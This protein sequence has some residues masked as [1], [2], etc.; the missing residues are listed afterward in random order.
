[1]DSQ[2]QNTGVGLAL[3]EGGR[4]LLDGGVK[5]PWLLG[6]PP[7]GLTLTPKF[8]FKLDDSSREFY[9]AY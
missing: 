2:S 4:F 3:R 1:M 7:V 9:F 5:T 6:Y 8:A